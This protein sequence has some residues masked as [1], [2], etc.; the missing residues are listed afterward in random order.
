MLNIPEDASDEAKIEL[1]E[2]E[3][4]TLCDMIREFKSG[5]HAQG[6]PWTVV[7]AGRLEKIWK[8]SSR[9]GIVRDEKGLFAIRDRFVENYLRLQVN[10]VLAG[11]AET[12]FKVPLAHHFSTE[13]EIEA[14]VEW[15]I[16]CETGMRISDYGLDKMFKYCAAAMECDDA[17]T[18]LVLCDHIL[19][20]SHQRSDL[21]SWFIQGGTATL[22]VIF[23]H[24]PSEQNVINPGR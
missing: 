20:V 15:A 18:L 6:S 9:R 3:E 13:E 22:N 1:I 7:P 16:T 12:N 5:K 24:R 2:R 4:E 17:E 11:H 14:F 8:D 19:S 10:T 21:A 23:E